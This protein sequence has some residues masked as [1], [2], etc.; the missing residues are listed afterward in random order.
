MME[1]GVG[2]QQVDGHK[3]VHPSNGH[4]CKR[5]NA[6]SENFIH[7]KLQDELILKIFSFL[8]IVSL[9]R[10][11]KVSHKWKILAL[12][13]SNWSDVDLFM[14]QTDIKNLLKAL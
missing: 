8:D 11:A 2:K 10:C 1:G 13:G 12:D 3:R 6:V 4:V 9:C 5:L 7:T 14:W